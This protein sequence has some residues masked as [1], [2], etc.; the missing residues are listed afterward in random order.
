MCLTVEHGEAPPTGPIP[1]YKVLRH[2]LGE[3]RSDMFLY[4][5]AP[6]P[7]EAE[8]EVERSTVDYPTTEIKQELIHGGVFHVVRDRARAESEATPVRQRIYG[9]RAVEFTA[10]P[11]DFVAWGTG[12]QA[13]FK[14]LYLSKVEF[15]KAMQ[16]VE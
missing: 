5:W 6:G 10:Y 9:M 14:K 12:R 13:C 11:E 2:W 7:N 15:D 3:L 4:I 8:H 1:V 16:V